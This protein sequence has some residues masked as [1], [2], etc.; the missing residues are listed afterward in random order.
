MPLNNTQFSLSLELTRLQPLQF[1]SDNI[2]S[3]TVDLLR[4]FQ[5]SGSDVLAENDLAE[6]FKFHQ[7][8]DNMAKIFE[9]AIVRP[10]RPIWT[11]FR[12]LVERI[13]L[14]NRPGPTVMRAVKQREYFPMVIECSFLAWIHERRSLATAFKRFFEKDLEDAPPEILAANPKEENIVGIIKACEDQTAAFSWEGYLRAASAD[15]HLSA[16]QILSPLPP[17]VFRSALRMLPTVQS[18]YRQRTMVITCSK[19]DGVCAMIVWAHHILGLNVLINTYIDDPDSIETKGPRQ[20]V[21]FG[22]S[23]EPAQV[24]L[25]L[26]KRCS[27]PSVVLMAESETLF[28]FVPDIDEPVIDAIYKIPARGFGK[29]VFETLNFREGKESAIEQMVHI[30]CAFVMILS[31]HLSGSNHPAGAFPMELGNSPKANRWCSI[32]EQ[33]LIQIMRLTFDNAG[34]DTTTV[35]EYAVIYSGKPL[36]EHLEIQ[37]PVYIAYRATHGDGLD[38]KSLK[39]LWR[40]A[41]DHMRK[42]SV[43]I[44]ALSFVRNSAEL[45]DF[46]LCNAQNFTTI[47]E[48]HP[49]LRFVKDW[50][51]KSRIN[52]SANTWFH[53]VALLMGGHKANLDYGSMSLLSSHGW[54][55]FISTYG[56]S[57][58]SFTD[59][60]Y[61][62]IYPGVP[63]RDGIRKHAII[64]GPIQGTLVGGGWGIT[65]RPGMATTLRCHT[66]Y[67]FHNPLIG[68]SSDDAFLVNLRMVTKN[69]DVY[70]TRRTGYLELF[71]SNWGLQ[72]TVSCDHTPTGDEKLTLPLGCATA[73]EITD[74][75]DKILKEQVLIYL[76]AGNHVSRWRALLAIGHYHRHVVSAWDDHRQVLLRETGCCYQCTMDQAFLQGGRWF[77]I[78]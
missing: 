36:D 78:L 29:H 39:F 74:N 41:V 25:N 51:G 73:S 75:P 21:L 7:I 58:P 20:S 38:D 18:L 77:I 37:R 8:D 1:L 56:T 40:G 63:S 26:E 6:L 52:V 11:S 4:R 43:L 12:P 31:R 65:E 62:T 2:G 16:G 27:I 22:K 28:R 32:S 70:E 60:G 17:V 9:E 55:V 13:W 53:A 47:M 49:L 42:L 54:S 30:T 76:T 61:I 69:G 23:V 19:G 66:S 72:K 46:L 71:H 44:L 64:D 35:E 14:D 68:E 34:I 67:D 33:Q 10:Q 15:L 3:A 45:N 5:N 24:I 48:A 50:D 59:A 57:D